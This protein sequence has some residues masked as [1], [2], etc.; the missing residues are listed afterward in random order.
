M[1]PINLNYQLN[2]GITVLYRDPAEMSLLSSKNFKIACLSVEP[3][4]TSHSVGSWSVS[5]MMT[6][7][8]VKCLGGPF[9]F[10]LLISV[11]FPVVGGS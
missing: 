4:D 2:S 11:I 3:T 5:L 8:S 6:M 1:L 7:C 9:L 10:A